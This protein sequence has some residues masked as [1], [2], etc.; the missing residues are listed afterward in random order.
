M[1]TIV[2]IFSIAG[3]LAMGTISPG[4]S[5][6]LVARKAVFATRKETLLLVFGLATGAFFFAMIAL[7]GLHAVLNAVPVA[8]LLLKIFGGLYL[9]YLGLS[10]WRSARKSLPITN[11]PDAA[12]QARGGG[13]AYM[14]GLATQLSNPKTAVWFAGA[15]AALMPAEP[16]LAFYLV[17]PPLAFMIDAIWYTIVTFALSSSFP[18]T[19]YLRH[20]AKL[21]YI[22][23][24]IMMLLG[25]KLISM[26]Q[27]E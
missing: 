2:A 14:L 12:N 19:T 4:P 23:G 21:D 17:V 15:F 1:S 26:A 13:R 5:F 27:E 7:L 10:I 8:Y 20:K 25:A 22:C 3:A 11:D 24:G 16:T 9:V 18:R 6:V